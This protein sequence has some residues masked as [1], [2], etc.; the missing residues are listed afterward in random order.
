MG[1]S[2]R[3]CR[4]SSW[5]VLDQFEL[6]HWMDFSVQ[7]LMHLESKKYLNLS[8]QYIS[9]YITLTLVANAGSSPHDVNNLYMAKEAICDHGITSWL[10]S[11]WISIFSSP[12]SSF[13]TLNCLV[14]IKYFKAISAATFLAAFFVR[15]I[16]KSLILTSLII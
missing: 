12:F 15:P 14:F 8:W 1:S 4:A 3:G 9:S 13:F 16:K 10:T 7:K 2:F 6:V 5:L 11:S